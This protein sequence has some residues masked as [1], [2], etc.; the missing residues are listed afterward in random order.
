MYINHETTIYLYWARS[1]KLNLKF[2]KVSLDEEI[3]EHG[4]ASASG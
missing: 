2:E 1:L 4:T 3:A